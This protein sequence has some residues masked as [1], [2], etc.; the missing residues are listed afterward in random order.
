MENRDSIVDQ[1]GEFRKSE[2]FLVVSLLAL[3]MGVQL[4]ATGATSLISRKFWLDEIFTNTLLSD[5]DF[6]HALRAL[7]NGAPDHHPPTY[8]L[9]ARGLFAD[10]VNEARLRFLSLG[11]V[12]LALAGTYVLLRSI[13]SPYAAMAA[14]LAL[15]CHPLIIE[16]AFEA[17]PYGLWLA[18]SVWLA[19]FINQVQR[20]PA[21]WYS[22]VMLAVTAAVLCTVHY[23]GIVALLCVVC[24]HIVFRKVPWHKGWWRLSALL[25]GPLALAACSPFLLEQRSALTV[26]TWVP[27]PSAAYLVTFIV[28]LVPVRAIIV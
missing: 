14:V 2:F 20:Q 12:L 1:A 15:W 4:Y 22:H 11:V 24:G 27:P 6:R 9:L 23:F 21:Q 3:T 25:A 28:D 13:C 5:R 19:V 7:K 26:P 10:D 17:R 8:Y 18:A 16:Y